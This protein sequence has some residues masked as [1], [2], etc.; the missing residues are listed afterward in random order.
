MNELMI[1]N[2]KIIEYEARAK[3]FD[4]YFSKYGFRDFEKLTGCPIKNFYYEYKKFKTYVEGFY[5]GYCKGRGYKYGENEPHYPLV[6]YVCNYLDLTFFTTMGKD[7]KIMYP[8]VS[9]LKEDYF[10]TPLSR[11]IEFLECEEVMRRIMLLDYTNREFFEE[12]RELLRKYDVYREGL[13]YEKS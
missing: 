1:D 7:C 11:D 13:P 2:Q 4:K 9:V 12:K 6:A 8:Y 10:V 3:E 5:N